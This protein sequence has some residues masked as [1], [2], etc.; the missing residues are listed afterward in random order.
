MLKNPHI[1]PMRTSSNSDYDYVF[2]TVMKTIGLIVD[3][4]QSEDDDLKQAK[5]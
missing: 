1:F 2:R 3:D 4:N 5:N